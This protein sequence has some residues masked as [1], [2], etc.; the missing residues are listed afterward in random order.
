M[1]KKTYKIGVELREAAM[2]GFREKNKRQLMGLRKI[3]LSSV[4]K[5]NQKS[6]RREEMRKET[7]RRKATE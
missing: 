1:R 2:N 6:S 7:K 5:K 3:S 4:K